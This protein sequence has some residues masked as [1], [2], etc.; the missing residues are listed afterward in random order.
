MTLIDQ[1]KEIHDQ[2]KAASLIY[3]PL[4]QTTQREA[5]ADGYALAKIQELEVK[6]FGKSIDL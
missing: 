5:F 6:T 3:Q 1:I 2:A 4:D